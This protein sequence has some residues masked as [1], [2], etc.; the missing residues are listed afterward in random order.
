VVAKEFFGEAMARELGNEDFSW[1]YIIC[2]EKSA[3][4]SVGRLE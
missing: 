2:Q 1:I 4:L 3:R